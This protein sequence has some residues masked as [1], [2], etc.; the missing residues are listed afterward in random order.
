MTLKKTPGNAPFQKWLKKTPNLFKILNLSGRDV[1]DTEIGL[2]IYRLKFTHT[3]KRTTMIRM[4]GRT[5]F[6]VNCALRNYF[7]A[8]LMRIIFVGNKKKN[9][10]NRDRYLEVYITC[11]KSSAIYNKDQTRIKNNKYL[12]QQ[13]AISSLRRDISIPVT[14]MLCRQRRCCSTPFKRNYVS[15]LA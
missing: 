11:L 3:T 10:H 6:A 8:F 13:R 14:I 15:V 7:E 4:L 12:S 1:N 5:N 2:L 9:P